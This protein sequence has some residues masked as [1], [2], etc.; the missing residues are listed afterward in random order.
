MTFK[1]TQF[2]E[3]TKMLEYRRAQF[4]D[5][6]QNLEQLVRQAWGSLGHRPKEKSLSVVTERRQV[7]VLVI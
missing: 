6:G 4:P 3:A 5:E 7:F 2:D 1:R